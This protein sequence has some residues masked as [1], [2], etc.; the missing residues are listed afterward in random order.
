MEALNPAVLEADVLVFVSPLYYFGFTAQL[1]TFIDRLYAINGKLRAQI[2]KKAI[3]LT[4]GAD[5]MIGRWM[6]LLLI[7]KRWFA[8]L[9]GNLL[10]KCVRWDVE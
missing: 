10:G 3:L 8:I 7:T 2:E 1:K 9:D 5:K 4:A 6:E